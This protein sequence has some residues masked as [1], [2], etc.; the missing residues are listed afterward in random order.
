MTRP[1]T[2]LDDDIIVALFLGND[3]LTDKMHI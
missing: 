3:K 2:S 1:S